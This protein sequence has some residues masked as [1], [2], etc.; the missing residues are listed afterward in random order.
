MRLFFSI[1]AIFVNA[2][3]V[4]FSIEFKEKAPLNRKRSKRLIIL[5]NQG[6]RNIKFLVNYD[7]FREITI[8]D[9]EYRLNL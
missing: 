5:L 2:K 9:F 8:L 6:E 4:I 7:S 1:F 3:E